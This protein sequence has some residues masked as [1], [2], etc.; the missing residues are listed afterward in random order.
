MVELLDADLGN[1]KLAIT[2]LVE[3]GLHHEQQHQE[4]LLTDIKHALWQNPLFP[5]Y[6]PEPTVSEV[7][8]RTAMPLSFVEFEGGL[9]EL[10]YQ[11]DG[12]HFDNEGPSHRVFL[13]DFV[14]ANRPVTNAEVLEF[15]RAGGYQ[16]PLLWLSDGWSFRIEQA[17]AHPLYWI[18]KSDGSFEQF[19]LHG[20][21]PLNPAETA[22]HLSYFEADAIARYFQSRLPSEYEW[23]IAARRQFGNAQPLDTLPAFD[24]QCIRPGVAQHSETSGLSQ[25]ARRGLG[26]DSKLL[27]RL[28]WLSSVKRCRG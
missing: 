1:D 14:L 3:L 21:H 18:A 2:A 12:F 11:G 19:S 24:P 25:L 7:A 20:V 8:T 6:R 17:L 22:S 23:E 13:E 16:E 10:G 27:L 26:V 5:A 9:H 28:P 15:I 4:L